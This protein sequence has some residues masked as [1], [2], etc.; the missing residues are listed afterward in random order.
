MSRARAHIKGQ[1]PTA[2]RAEACAEFARKKAQHR[3]RLWQRRTILATVGIFASFTGASIWWLERE[4]TFEAVA[5]SASDYFWQQTADAGFK[6]QQIYL[7]GRHYTDLASINDALQVEAG[8]P[9]LALDIAAIKDH[10]E[11][12]PEVH[13]V[14]IARVLPNDLRIAIRERM[15]VAV[16]QSRG[17][18][19][20]IDQDGV[21]L[22]SAKYQPKNQLPV[23]VGDDA[24]SHVSQLL[25]ILSTQPDLRPHVVAAVRVGERRWNLQLSNQVTVLL[26][27]EGATRA[28]ARFGQLVRD[29]GIL[30]RAVRAI[31]LRIEDRIF[32]T[33]MDEK[34]TPVALKFAKDA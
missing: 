1:K 11:A 7:Y 26:P 12:I 29:E 31:D 8:D 5:N 16:W 4:G 23:I 22:N 3:R 6:V 9:I 21:V 34:A 20:L 33:P 25:A 17:V 14:R 32:V 24:P 28:W 30:T 19:K 2:T 27:E 10:I 13:D 18:Q 15:P